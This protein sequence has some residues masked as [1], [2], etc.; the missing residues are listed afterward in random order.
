MTGT[1]TTTMSPAAAAS[2]LVAADARGPSSA[3][4]SASV[5]GPRECRGISFLA[6]SA[7]VFY[8]HPD[9]VYVPIP[10][11][12]PDQ[13]CFAV[14]ASRTSPVV[15][16]F[17]TAAQATAEVTAECGNYEMWQRGIDAVSQHG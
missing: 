15:D 12:A 10:D 7:T 17:F 16:D 9:V 1:V 2:P 6:R 14:A 8:S 4:V 5:L 3:A 13:V 11:L